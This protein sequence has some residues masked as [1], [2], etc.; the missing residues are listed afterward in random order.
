M[1]KELSSFIKALLLFSAVL[2]VSGYLLGMNYLREYFHP[3][4]WS[5]LIFFV[6]TTFAFH[7]GLVKSCKGDPKL[8]FRYYMAATGIKLFG[9]MMIIIAYALINRAEAAP[10]IITFLILY[11]FFMTFEVIVSYKASRTRIK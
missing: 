9:Y 4:F 1:L 7:Y 3:V 10:F 2:A 8:F 5:I 11:F 6:I